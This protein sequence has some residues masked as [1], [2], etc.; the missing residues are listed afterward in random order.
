MSGGWA[1]AAA[2]E[3]SEAAAA[4]EAALDGSARSIEVLEGELDA[5]RAAA[6]ALRVEAEAL[7]AAGAER[8]DALHISISIEQRWLDAWQGDQL[9]FTAPVAVGMG[10]DP[11]AGAWAESFRTPRGRRDVIDKVENP[12]WIPP[13]WHYTEQSYAKGVAVVSVAE[14]AP[15]TLSDGSTVEVRGASMGRVVEGE[16]QAFGSGSDAVVDG[17]IFMP[18]VHHPQRRYK[19]VMGTRMLDLGEG[20]AIHGTAAPW[21]VG[22]ASSHGCLRMTNED[23]EALYPLV[24]QGTPVFI[25]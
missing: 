7:S 24:S 22:T 1:G 13:A 5:Q 10:D 23:I 18:P 20:Y 9:V 4:V 14:G 15:A 6:D 21:T 25:Y 2:L 12:V 8:G 3:R 17:K 11:E 19:A 16:F